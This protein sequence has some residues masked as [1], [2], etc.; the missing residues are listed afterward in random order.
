MSISHSGQNG[1]AMQIDHARF[2][3]FK[4]LRIGVGTDKDDAIAFD[5]YG[6]RV[7]IPVVDGV[8]VAVDKDQVG[9]FRAITRRE[10][11]QQKQ[12]QNECKAFH[13]F[14][15][16]AVNT[17]ARERLISQRRTYVTEFR[18]SRNILICPPRLS[19]SFASLRE[20]TSSCP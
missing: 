11:E 8:D 2:C 13:K 7:G 20:K 5:H 10:A 12:A 18:V 16:S 9:S 19:F 14:S 4:F 15:L 1:F 6:F 3:A 17:V